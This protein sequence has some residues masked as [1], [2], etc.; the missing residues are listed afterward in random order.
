MMW[1]VSYI[2]SHRGCDTKPEMY[3]NV[4][5]SR[6]RE[7]NLLKISAQLRMYR[8]CLGSRVSNSDMAGE[9]AILVKYLFENL[10]STV[11]V[12]RNAVLFYTAKIYGIK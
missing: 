9:G 6:R 12:C 11:S 10:V 2:A 8:L 5:G 1:V 7:H 3:R 4:H